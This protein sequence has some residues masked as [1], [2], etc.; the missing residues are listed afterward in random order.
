MFDQ[1]LEAYMKRKL[2]S[3]RMV[4]GTV[5][6]GDRQTCLRNLSLTDVTGL[7]MITK[8]ATWAIAYC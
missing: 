6:R 3:F 2:T 5:A 8:N 1:D 4:C 7:L